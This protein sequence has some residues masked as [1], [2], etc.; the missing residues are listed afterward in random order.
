MS[1]SD[2]TLALPRPASVR[3]ISLPRRES[4]HPSPSDWRD[5]VLYFLLPD[6]FSDG[7]EAGRP[8]LD[9]ANPDA[10]PPAGFRFDRL[11]ES[12]GGRYQGGTIDGVRS[13]LGYLKGL[14]VTAVWVGPVFKQ[15][16]FGNTFH[17][18][19]IQDF[20]DVDPRFGTRQDLVKLV[21]EAHAEGLRVILDV[22]F[23]HSGCNWN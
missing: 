17:G 9:R 19:A 10:A 3:E 5:E 7:G 15:R 11:G 14:G 23:N 4:Y 22:I 8:Q 12:G 20:L 16:I 6:R 1:F 21:S 13:K 18:Y 2:S